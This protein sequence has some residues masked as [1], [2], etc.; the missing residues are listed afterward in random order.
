MAMRGVAIIKG[1]GDLQGDGTIDVSMQ[2]KGFTDANS[3]YCSVMASIGSGIL[4]SS[5]LKASAKAQIVSWYGYNPS[6]SYAAWN[7]LLDDFMLIGG[8]L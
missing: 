3:E 8:V 7:A 6:A 2:Y 4:S 1:L 5:A